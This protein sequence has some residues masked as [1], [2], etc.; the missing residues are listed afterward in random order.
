K[1]LLDKKQ[2]FLASQ[3]NI[4]VLPT[5]PY[6][7]NLSVRRLI[8]HWFT[9][10][11]F[12]IYL[13]LN[14]KSE[15]KIL[16]SSIPPELLLLTKLIAKIK[17]VHCIVDVRDIW[18]D[19]FPIKGTTG[20]IFSSYCN[21]LYKVSLFI[22]Q[23][24]NKYIYVSPSFSNWISRYDLSNKDQC[25]GFL[26]YDETRWG[27]SYQLK[28]L[29]GSDSKI[30]LVYVGYLES[31]FDLSGIILEVNKNSNIELVIIGNGS[32]Q[33]EYETLAKTDRVSFS[34][35]LKPREVVEVLVT[36]DVGVLPI[37]HT[38]QMP[39]KLFDYLGARLPVL[40]IGHSDSSDFVITQ[41]IGWSTSFDSAS[42]S[43]TIS[44]ID[45]NSILKKRTRLLSISSLYSKESSYRKIKSFIIS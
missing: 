13:V 3:Y 34:G 29:Q 5:I 7:S 18:P 14:V 30:K 10:F 38:A 4:K 22:N 28:R 1:K 24:E 39:N 35:L 44:E 41:G 8:A 12:F 40:A 31:Q 16:V 27:D 11:S 21:I 15:D 6:S 23:E 17:G 36:C 45:H 43:Q 42:I 25:F 2:F 9:A 19:A 33:V 20:K 26:G 37:S 32:K